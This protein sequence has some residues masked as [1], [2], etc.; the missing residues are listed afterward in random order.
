MSVTTSNDYSQAEA[1]Q[2]SGNLYRKTEPHLSNLSD[3][4]RDGFYRANR[5]LVILTYL[6]V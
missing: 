6:A 5:E 1:L 3:G 2:N 4:S